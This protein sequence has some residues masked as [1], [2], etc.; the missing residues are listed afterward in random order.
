MLCLAPHCDFWGN[1]IH[2]FAPQTNMKPKNHHG[3][4]KENHRLEISIFGFRANSAMCIS[5]K[6]NICYIYI[7]KEICVLFCSSY[8]YL[9]MNEFV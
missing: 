5:K 8:N 4:V 2:C 7:K 6:I 1:A 3:H 9:P